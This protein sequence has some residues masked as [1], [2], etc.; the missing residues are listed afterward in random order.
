M[1]VEYKTQRKEVAMMLAMDQISKV[2]IAPGNQ[3]SIDC[4]WFNLETQVKTASFTGH[5]RAS[6]NKNGVKW[7]PYSD[8]DGVEQ[9]VE[10][11]IVESDGDYYLMHAVQPLQKLVEHG[12]FA[13]GDLT[14]RAVITVPWGDYAEWVTG[15]SARRVLNYYAWLQGPTYGWRAPVRLTPNSYLTSELLAEVAHVAKNPAAMP[16][17]GE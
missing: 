4:K 14:G 11:L 15:A 17:E 5:A 16:T 2:S 10:C 9:L 12:V 8:M 13:T 6:H 7:Q 3:T 1:G